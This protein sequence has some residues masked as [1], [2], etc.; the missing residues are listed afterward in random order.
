VIQQKFITQM[1]HHLIHKLLNHLHHL[2]Q[3]YHLVVQ[4]AHHQ[5]K[6]VQAQLLAVLEIENN[7]DLVINQ[8]IK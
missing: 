7:S 2:C 3:L 8:E 4:V 1:H 5:V 6:I